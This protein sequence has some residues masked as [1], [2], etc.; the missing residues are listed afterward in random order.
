MTARFRPRQ[1]LRTRAEF[2]RVFRRGQRLDGRLFTLVVAPNGLD[3]D[4]LGLAV[5]RKV[6]G[7]VQRNRAKRLVRES[8]RRLSPEGRSA[9][10]VVV[11]AKPE[12]ARLGQS[13][14]QSEL[15]QRLR[16][17]RSTPALVARPAPASPR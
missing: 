15:E 3:A 16:R 12:L 2:D 13:E 5:S 17:V 6:G 11:L 4:R 7:A 10:D 9:L 8:F 14:V 1:R